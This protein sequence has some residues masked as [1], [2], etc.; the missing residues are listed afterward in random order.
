MASPPLKKERVTAFKESLRNSCSLAP[1][2]PP[3][4]QY[5]T[6]FRFTTS[7]FSPA[8]SFN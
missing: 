8:F 2:R 1:L 7:G 5:R 3:A 4:P 6:F